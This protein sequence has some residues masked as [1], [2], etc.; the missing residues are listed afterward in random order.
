M[1]EERGNSLLLTIM[2]L[3]IGLAVAGGALGLAEFDYRNAQYA[4]LSAKSNYIAEAGIY[5]AIAKL[6]EEPKWL[7]GFQSIKFAEGTYTVRV[8]AQTFESAQVDGTLNLNDASLESVPV[9][10]QLSA[11]GNA[12]MRAKSVLRVLYDVK[13]QKILEWD[14]NNN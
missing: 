14:E 13:Q 6:K 2:L 1:A 11:Q 5:R 7:E 12:A 4:I 9:I 3:L 8:V 10:V